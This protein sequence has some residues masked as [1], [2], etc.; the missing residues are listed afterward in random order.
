MMNIIVLCYTVQT[1][2]H[3]VGFEGAKVASEAV[4]IICSLIVSI[5]S[6]GRGARESTELCCPY[7][8]VQYRQLQNHSFLFVPYIF[9]IADIIYLHRFG[10]MAKKA[11]KCMCN[12][13]GSFEYSFVMAESKGSLRWTTPTCDCAMI[14][15]YLLIVLQESV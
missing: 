15:C 8:P 6:T 9:F 14:R 12:F 11:V 7:C 1:N 10:F 5:S 2:R 4:L 3:I 13:V